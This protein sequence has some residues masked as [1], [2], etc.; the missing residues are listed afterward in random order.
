MLRHVKVYCRESSIHGFPY[1]VNKEIG[2]VEKIFWGLMVVM[3]FISCGALIYKIGVKVK[4][5]AV[6][7]YTSDSAIDI[8]DVSLNTY[9]GLLVIYNFFFRFPL[10]P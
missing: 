4:E 8:T 7:T 1:L 6:V 9:E 10:L 3:S 5:D 2:M